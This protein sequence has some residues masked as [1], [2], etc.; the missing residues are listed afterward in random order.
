M[1]SELEPGTIAGRLSDFVYNLRREAVPNQVFDKTKLLLLDMVER[2][3]PRRR[4]ISASARSPAC[5]L[6][7]RDRQR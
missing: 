1:N 3:S 5:V 4:S 7:D 2:L 6:S